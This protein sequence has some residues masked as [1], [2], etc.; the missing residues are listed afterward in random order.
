MD[1]LYDIG[2]LLTS[3][4]TTYKIIVAEKRSIGS[5]IVVLLLF[6]IGC[7]AATAASMTWLSWF[8]P[9]LPF[10]GDL[11]SAI[12]VYLILGFLVYDMV[13]WI[14]ESALAHGFARMLGGRGTFTLTLIVYGYSWVGRL[15]YIIPALFGLWWRS[16]IGMVGLLGVG[17][18]LSTIAK[19]VLQ[20]KGMEIVHEL[21]LGRSLLAVVLALTVKIAIIVGVVAN[22]AYMTV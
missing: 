16:P 19:V 13:S 1:L 10:V 2:G 8:L 17:V 3:P 6:S 5:A 9:R 18:V 12:M 11:F 4:R 7:G 22:I 15:F 20:V 21:G 14:I